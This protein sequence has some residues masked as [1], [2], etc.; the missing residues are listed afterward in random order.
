MKQK[1]LPLALTGAFVLSAVGASAITNEQM[2]HRFTG[3][4]SPVKALSRH[5]PQADAPLKQLPQRIQASQD[6]MATVTDAMAWGFLTGPDDTD[7]F[8]SQTFTLDGWYYAASEIT[9]YDNNYQEVARFSVEAPEGMSVNQIEPFGAVTYNLFDRTNNTNEIAVFHHAVT[10]DYMGKFWVDIYSLSTGEKVATYDDCETAMF[11]DATTSFTKN[12]KF[13]TC[14]ADGEGNLN[15]DVYK[16]AGWDSEL[17]TVEHTFTV[18]EKLINYMDASYINAYN[19]DGEIYYVLNHYEKEYMQPSDDMMSDPVPTEDNTFVMEVYNGDYAPVT[20]LNIP[21]EGGEDAYYTFGG[22]GIF[23]TCDLSKGLYTGDDRLNFVVTSYD[24]LLESDGYVYHF[25]VYDEKG[26]KVANIGNRAAAWFHLSSLKGFEDQVALI[27]TDVGEGMIEMVDLPSCNLAVQLPGI[28]DGRFISS[29]LDRCISGGDY[30]YV[31]S[32]SQGDID[33][34]NNVI[35][36]IGWYDRNGNIDHYVNFNLGPNAEYFSAY[37][38]GEILNPY[39]V[40]SDDEYEYVF[41]AKQRDP[42]TDTLS[43]V[44]YVAK[45]SG[46]ILRQFTDDEQKGLYY[47]GGFIAS[48]SF[49][50]TLFVAYLD[51]DSDIYTLDFYELPFEKFEAGGDGTAE[52]PYL[53]TS[54]GDL[55]QIANEPTAYY[56]LAC[57]LDMTDCAGTWNPIPAFNGTLDGANHSIKGLYL[58]CRED[59]CGLFGSLEPESVVKNIIFIDPVVEVTPKNYYTGVLA[60]ISMKATID[61]IHVFNP[62]INGTNAN[63]VG[64][65]VGEASYYTEFTNCSVNDLT[66][67][68]PSAVSVGG[69]AGDTR[70]S[71]NVTACYVGKLYSSASITAES[72]VGG[73]VGTTGSD[74]QVNN[75][76]VN[77]DVTAQHTVGGVVGKSSSRGIIANNIVEGNVYALG[78]DTDNYANIGGVVG[79]LEADWTQ[80]STAKVVRRNIALQNK[81]MAPGDAK[82]A[83]RIVG[84]T[85]LDATYADDEKPVAESGLL[86]NYANRDM[87]LSS[88]NVTSDDNTSAEGADFVAVDV[89]KSFYT[90]LSFKYGSSKSSPWKESGI[91]PV[92][93]FENTAKALVLSEK[94]IEAVEGETYSLVAI[95]Y[96]VV[97]DAIEVTSSDE[98]VATITTSAANDG[99]ANEMLIEVKILTPGNSTITATCDDLEAV[100][101]VTGLSSVE[102]LAAVSTSIDFNGTT[103]CLAGAESIE[104]YTADGVRVASATGELLNVSHLDAGIY[105]VAANRADCRITRKIAIR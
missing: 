103:L 94:A 14:K 52:N 80:S 96:G 12:Y 84:W 15:I 45:E 62:S 98:N 104:V 3:V 32:V 49:K 67:N 29:N 10:S 76:H 70:T 86:K 102:E 48:D 58:N 99:A 19:L 27:K 4:D 59:Y 1:I 17:P 30:K 105:I 37:I 2:K 40:D 92:L 66:I 72:M 87:R 21:L 9:V 31:I 7:W 56:Q 24:Y 89:D 38:N 11:L 78:T 36:A 57:D 91:I 8:Y 100:C 81:V 68:I 79:Y 44:L 43:N 95:V 55:Q 74:S 61:N 26:E 54:I 77:I 23:S 88:G 75:C 18:E 20:T 34:N 13:I 42:S 63:T 65:L 69:I 6:P 35:S 83:H 73:V 22:F 47:N 16:R 93:Y 50:P 85:S 60:G 33:D 64:G 53:I 41:I 5:F 82:A 46:E 90:D 51:E 97:A 28:I 39:L 25:N 101:A 71:S